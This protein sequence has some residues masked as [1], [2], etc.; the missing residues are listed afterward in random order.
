MIVTVLPG[1]MLVTVTVPMR[2]PAWV[3]VKVMAMVH[4]APPPSM[5]G[6]L[7]ASP[8]SPVG[9]MLVIA[10]LEV[11]L[12]ISVTPCGELVMP[13]SVPLKVTLVVLAVST[14][15]T[16]TLAV[17]IVA[18]VVAVTVTCVELFTAPAVTTNV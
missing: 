6:Q 17:F 4:I 7:F 2:V 9:T 14:G 3:G 1:A 15:F 12:F 10:T 5:A 18:P 11:E 16:V 13:I 8:K